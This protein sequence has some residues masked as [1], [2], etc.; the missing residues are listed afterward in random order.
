MT[1]RFDCYRNLSCQESCEF[2]IEFIVDTGFITPEIKHSQSVIGGRQRE[3]ANCLDWMIWY[4]LR[5]RKAIF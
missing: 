1:L 4:R 5:K 3:A 2:E